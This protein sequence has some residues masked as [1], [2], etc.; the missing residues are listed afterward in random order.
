MSWTTQTWPFSPVFRNGCEWY[1]TV[2]NGDDFEDWPPDEAEIR[3]REIKE[4][5]I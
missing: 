1:N 5:R 2:R 4:E 3:E